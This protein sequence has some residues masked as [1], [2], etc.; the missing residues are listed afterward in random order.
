MFNLGFRPR[1]ICSNGFVL[2][3]FGAALL[4]DLPSEVDAEDLT[5]LGGSVQV[6]N[7]GFTSEALRLNTPFVSDRLAGPIRKHRLPVPVAGLRWK[8]YQ[9]ALDASSGGERRHRNL[10]VSGD[11]INIPFG[12]FLINHSAADGGIHAGSTLY[13]A[14]LDA[15]QCNPQYFLPFRGGVALTFSGVDSAGAEIADI[16]VRPG[17]Y[18]GEWNV[19]KGHTRKP[20]KMVFSPEGRF[21]ATASSD[22][23]VRLWNLHNHTEVCRFPSLAQAA[24]GGTIRVEQMAFSWFGEFLAT[25]LQGVITVRRTNDGDIMAILRP[26]FTPTQMQFSQDGASIF[27]FGKTAPAG[28]RAVRFVRMP[29]SASPRKSRRYRS[30]FG[31]TSAIVGFESIGVDE[32]PRL[33][34]LITWDK[35]APMLAVWDPATGTE[36]ADLQIDAEAIVDAAL[37]GR[38]DLLAVLGSDGKIVFWSTRRWR[39]EPTP[40]V[41]E[42]N[43]CRSIQFVDQDKYLATISDD[44]WI[45]VWDAP[46]HSWLFDQLPDEW[47]PRAAVSASSTAGS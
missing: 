25:E 19:L 21:L 41:Y 15:V 34:W 40:V 11:D 3:A 39:R 23:S 6:G 47:L 45:M 7:R 2:I 13:F 12:H 30:R 14:P 16:A 32:S 18:V 24:D 20:W 10:A 42:Q 38:Q 17:L 44:G 5:S 28:E 36:L 37:N 43:K 26:D 46:Q 27:V 1:R 4:G 33:K 35:D 8:L 9:P 29:L 22:N 31:A